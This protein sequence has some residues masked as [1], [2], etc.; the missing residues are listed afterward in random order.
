[1]TSPALAAVLAAAAQ[2]ASRSGVPLT[3]QL[4]KARATTERAAIKLDLTAEG[5]GLILEENLKVGLIRATGDGRYWLEEA[6]IARAEAKLRR[7]L[8]ILLIFLVSAGI[9]AWALLS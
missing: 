9:S 3:D 8:L 7:F 2:K 1:M 6:V 4:K 5:S